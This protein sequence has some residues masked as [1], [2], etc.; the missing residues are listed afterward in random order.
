MKMLKRMEKNMKSISSKIVTVIIISCILVSVAVGTV[1]SIFGN[2]IIEK[3]AKDKLLLTAQSKTNEFDK[4]ILGVQGSVENLATSLYSGLD[5]EK[6][7]TD[8]NY[9]N[10][11][12]TIVK[13][14]G[15][16]TEGAMGSYFYFAPELTGG[17]YGAWY[18]KTKTNGDF[19]A[20]PLGDLDI[21]D[22][23]NEDMNWYYKP[24]EAHKGIW[25]DPYVDDVLNIKMISYVVPMY[26][27]NILIG[28][29]GMDIDFSYFSKTVSETKVYD[30]G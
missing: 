28:V 1:N 29:V 18:S 30:T 14:F 17:V 16:T 26:K 5:L 23:T 27:N 24:I 10:N 13:R 15:E 3:E 7:K 4:T 11:L 9:L 19:E 6:L 22:P 20:Q 25:L 12:Q 21:F 2:N 8:P